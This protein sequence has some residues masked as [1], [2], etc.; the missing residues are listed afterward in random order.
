M[1]DDRPDLYPLYELTASPI[2]NRP[3]VTGLELPNPIRIDGYAAGDSYGIL[4]LDTTEPPGRLTISIKD[5][6]GREVVRHEV[7]LDDLGFESGG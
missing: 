1:R 6:A 5:A 2:A 4:E 3:F 7:A